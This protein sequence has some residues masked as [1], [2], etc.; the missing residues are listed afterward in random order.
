MAKT[1][2]TMN[3]IRA[4]T[5]NIYHQFPSSK[6]LTNRVALD[7][8]SMWWLSCT[9]HNICRNKSRFPPFSRTAAF[10]HSLWEESEEAQCLS[11]DKLMWDWANG[12]WS[13]ICAVRNQEVC[14]KLQTAAIAIPSSPYHLLLTSPSEQVIS[15]KF[16]VSLMFYARGSG[17][18]FI[19]WIQ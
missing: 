13:S 12:K 2:M 3:R 1:S 6:A 11:P 4:W 17:C 8:F 14:T 15:I 19:T 5:S 18:I 7:L 10:T 9:Q 16:V